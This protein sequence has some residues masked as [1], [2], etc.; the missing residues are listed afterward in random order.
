MHMD[1]EGSAVALGSLISL[2]ILKVPF[3]IDT[4]LAITENRIS[5]T[6][7]K[8]QDIIKAHNGKTIQ[9]IHTDAEG[10]MVLADALSIASKEKPKLIIDYATLTGSCVAALTE[11]YSGV[12]TNRSKANNLMLE[13]G[14]RSGE[15]VWPFPMD[16]DLEE[17]IKSEIADLK[18]CAISEYGDHIHAAKF[19]SHF[20]PKNIPW[21]H[22][23]LSAGKNKGGLAHI[24]TDATGFGVKLTVELFKS[25]KI[26]SVLKDL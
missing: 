3:P 18:Q 9:T 5:S 21:I 10:R 6:A 11:K 26:T 15:R 7:Y 20:V 13:A 25:K 1:M 23:D 8:A 16:D 19:L 14:I 12:F 4:W 24:P 17:P 22:I 2:A